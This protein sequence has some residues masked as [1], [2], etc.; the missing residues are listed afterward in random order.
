MDPSPGQD[1]PRIL[2]ID[3]DPG[4]LELCL[5]SFR[6]DPERYR[7]SVAQTIREARQAISRETP[8]III[9]DWIL[10]DGKG[11]DILPRT[12]GL[13]T[14][15]LIIMTSHGNEQI[16]V[17]IM[18]SGAIDYV[19]KSATMFHELPQIAKRAL[20]DWENL[21][22]RRGAVSALLE[23]QKRLADILS[24]LPDAVFAV[25]TEGRVIAWNKAIEKMTGIPPFAIVGKGDHEYSVP[26]YGERRPILIDLVLKDDPGIE[27][28]YTSVI[29]D[30]EILAAETY[31]PVL[32]GKEGVYLWG[33]AS[34]LFDS[35]G[36]RIGAIELIRDI[37]EQK[38]AELLLIRNKGLLT[39][40]LNASQDSIILMDPDGTILNINNEGARL[41]GGVASAIAGRNAFD[42]LPPE[43]ARSRRENLNRVVTEGT[44]LTFEDRRDEVLFSNSLFPVFSPDHTHVE[45]VAIYA[46][47]ITEQ[48]K[49]QEQLLLK[50]VIFEASITANSIAGNDGC[51]TDVNPAFLAMWGYARKDEVTGRPIASFFADGSEVKSILE[52]LG[53][54]DRWSGEFMAKRRDGST[55]SALGSATT[56]T[57]VTGNKIGYQSTC[58]D[59]TDKKTAEEEARRLML[60][61]TDQKEILSALIN[62]IADEVWYNDLKR[63]FTLVNPQAIQEFGLESIEGS[64]AGK[65]LASLDVRRPDGTPRPQEET[66]TFRAL[67]GEVVRNNLELVRIPSRND[68]RY[69]EVTA[70]PVRDSAG[71]IVGAVS[72]VRDVTDQRKAEAAV[73]ESETRFRDL[74]D[75]MSAGVV[76]FEPVNGGDDFIIR[77]FNHGAEIIE[78]V[79]KEAVIGR[80]VLE[81]FPGARDFGIFTVFQRVARTGIAELFPARIYTDNRISGWRENYVYRLPSGEVVALYEDL[82]AKKQA[83]EAMEVSRERFRIAAR[84]TNDTIWDW[85]LETGNLWWSESMRSVFGYSAKD[86]NTTITWW[87][88]HV[89]ADDRERVTHSVHT[90]IGEGKENWSE[91][92][93]FRKADG[94]YASVLD[95]G[96]IMRDASGRATRMVGALLDLTE[97]KDAERALA[98]SEQKFRTFAD[99]TYDWE[100]W[101]RPDGTYQYTSP[102][103]ERITGYSPGEFYRDPDLLKRI[104]HP[105]DQLKVS[106]HIEYGLT[107]DDAE[108]SIEFRIISKSGSTVWIGHICHPIYDQNGQF[109]GRRGSNRDITQRKMAEDALKQSE[110]RFRALFQNS[111]D[112]IMVLDSKGTTMYASPSAERIFG[113]DTEGMTGREILEKVHPA[114][115]ERIRTE[116]AAVY[117]KKKPGI[118]TEY[119][120]QKADGEYLWV[121]SIGVNLLEVPKV[122][123]VVFTTRPIQ[124]RKEAEAA[125]HESE[126]RLRLAL[127][128][129]DAGFWDWDL[130]TGKAVFSERFYTMLGYRPGEFP[131]SYE[132][133][134]ALMHP[135]D[136]ERVIPDLMKQIDERCTNCEIE[137]R[138]LSRDGD[139][140][141][142]LGRGKIVESDENGIPSRMTGV[143]IDIT[144]RRLME[145]EIRSLNTV[146]EQRV[147]D[148]TEALSQANQALEE[149]NAQRIEAEQKLRASVD[150][151]SMLLKEIHHRVKNNLQIIASLLNLQSRY[152]RDEQTLAAIRESQNRV[153]AMAL[154]HEKLYR[155]EDI[156]HIS[157][158]EYIRFLGTGLFQFYDAKARGI[159]FDI[160]IHDVS[161]DINSA[162][163][164]GL[165]I[166]ELISNSLK[167]AFPEGRK[168]EI[169][170]AVTK[171]G[172]TITV[173]FRDTGIG[174]P[175]DLDWKNTPSLGLRLVNTLV[176]QMNGTIELDRSA[177]TQFLLVVYE[178]G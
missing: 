81:A 65:L 6:D 76:I 10:P 12:E 21:Q 36:V 40:L 134:T 68:W 1:F 133:W 56:I 130:K 113:Y 37:T 55:F 108:G 141:W 42:L 4:H 151:K 30:G 79:K 98:D 59:V 136:R 138:C 104:T 100:Y 23:E 14:V 147:K 178:K 32:N 131:A 111:S 110:A 72:V 69:R 124:K 122:N 175:A 143:N 26:F 148:R 87:E 24:F 78:N 62:S 123:G 173:R 125:L 89:H 70:A 150:E 19:V 163:P 95:R 28:K 118:P 142:I 137:Y 177:G 97:R 158:E 71:I 101:I 77:D 13:V 80:S 67:N 116:M 152:I 103:C 20:R 126:E 34:T 153:K 54:T 17:E 11:L 48:K 165:I 74:F 8:D 57:D 107:E 161:V 82:T 156:S 159:R 129:A 105:A 41:L 83:E 102:S 38:K 119:R 88:D 64:D 94:S 121:D 45:Q 106:S 169:A 112:I 31:L 7:V 120:M 16:A 164:L 33:E 90:A 135:E 61:V 144:N 50:N 29:R 114:D 171:D 170:I 99:Y 166:N 91:E 176:D 49:A 167:Y 2:I 18:K 58:F 128:G 66:P 35:R 63:G 162:I 39:A 85:N 132:A 5:R 46:R 92:Y 86:L 174:I 22:S 27:G 75:N 109:I 47:D 51:I 3:D 149:E 155:A 168:G 146:L 84:A 96:S 52:E 154:V 60:E 53:R 157:L 73:R 127:E 43:V 44:P 139:W 15:P 115:R 140:I 9:A 117:T 172:H 160:D 93:R 145:S 25:D